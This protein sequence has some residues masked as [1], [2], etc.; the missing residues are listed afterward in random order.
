MKGQA[1]VIA[2]GSMFLAVHAGSVASAI[3]AKTLE[4]VAV[5]SSRGSS[6]PRDR[7]SV[8]CISFAL[9]VDSL[10][11]EPLGKPCSGQTGQPRAKAL[12]PDWT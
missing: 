7:T 10:S 12:K 3:Q 2:E 5:P 9:Q 1:L 11:T 4:W 6:R 8:S